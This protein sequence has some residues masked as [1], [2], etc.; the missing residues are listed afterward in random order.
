LDIEDGV[1][2][3]LLEMKDN[4]IADSILCYWRGP[5]VKDAPT[6]TIYTRK[7]QD[8]L[9][10]LK[11]NE[12]V[13][14]NPGFIDIENENFRLKEDSPAFKLG[15]QKIPI[16]KIGLYKDEFRKNLPKRK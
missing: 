4:L 1:D 16:E 9:Q 10:K 7:N 6:G 13:S 3:A 12:I 5:E 14:G 11:G 2:P 8:F 15:F